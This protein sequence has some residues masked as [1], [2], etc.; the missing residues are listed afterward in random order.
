MEGIGLSHGLF[1]DGGTARAEEGYPPI[2]PGP[3]GEVLR[4][5]IWG[6]IWVQD[7]WCP[8]IPLSLMESEKMNCVGNRPSLACPVG[9]LGLLLW[10]LLS[11]LLSAMISDLMPAS[12][13][14]IT[15]ITQDG[16]KL[17]FSVETGKFSYLQVPGYAADLSAK[18]D[19]GVYLYDPAGTVLLDASVAPVESYQWTGNSLYLLR[20]NLAQ[21]IKTEE[22]WTVYEKHIELGAK[23]T[24]IGSTPMSRAIEAC[25][26]LPL[27]LVGE[28]WHHHLHQS[29]TIRIRSEPY[30]TLL[31][32]LVDIGSSGDGS[33]HMKSDLDFN[34]HGLNLIGDDSFGLAMAIHPEKPAAYYV[35][36]DAIRRS[37]DACFHLGIYK[38]HLENTNSVSF[39]LAFF[40]P[41]DPEWGLRS[42]LQK[43]VSIYPESFVGSLGPQSGMVVGSEYNYNEYPDPKDFHIGAIWNGFKAKNTDYGVHSL[44]YLWPTGF[45]DRGMRLTASS[46]PTGPDPSWEADIAACLSLYQDYDQGQN[47]FQQTCTGP[48]PFEQCTYVNPHGRVY[49]PVYEPESMD[50]ENV[51]AL[52]VTVTNFPNYLFGQFSIHEPLLNSLLQNESGGHVGAM[53]F[54]SAMA[55]LGWDPPY[56]R[57]F[58]GGLN[59]DPGLEISPSNESS[60]GPAPTQTNNFGHL[61]LE[62]AKRANGLYGDAY[63]YTD[64]VEGLNLHNGAAVDTVGAYLRQ[65]FNPDM[66]RV[67][68]LPLGYDS[69]SGR[70]VTLE[71]LA[72]FSFLKALRA[73]LPADAAL[74]MNGKP[75]SGILG[76]ETD[77]LMDEMLGREIDGNWIDELYDEDLQ[78]R[79]RRI[80]RMRMSA[81]Q[82]PITF[83]AIFD[84]AGTEPELLEQMRQYL[85]LYTAKGLYID[86]YRYGYQGEKFFWYEKPHNQS[87]IQE[88]KKHSDAVHALTVAGWEPVPFAEPFDQGGSVIPD[89][90]IERFGKGFFTLYNG[91]DQTVS[92]SVRMDWQNIGLL[93]VSVRDWETGQVLPFTVSGDALTVF[94]LS[95]ERHTVQILEVQPLT[96]YL[97]LVLR[98]R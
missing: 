49:G 94:G 46:V 59:P 93:P 2:P 17:V 12:G 47:P 72:L 50:Y 34:L 63:L 55:E 71:H 24:H 91:G 53:S 8:S 21:E 92:F 79:L 23:M 13:D 45:I 83:W 32:R 25:L 22:R 37:Y 56:S 89:I 29:E 60:P 16:F 62:I 51:R 6:N 87:V 40:S 69:A 20:E 19:L 38:D 97:P 81:Y 82:R 41:D 5:E 39:N 3:T 58:L 86:L 27:D 30:Q 74:S 26:Q 28:R 90:L 66:L 18:P 31:T 54:A 9:F 88:Y 61:N 35:R 43:Y 77:F 73:S 67:A 70:V 78:T 11:M 98:E 1:P 80:N 15:L 33:H 64:P 68:V 57:C 14:T 65:D 52:Q 42:A 36:Y 48:I 95:L 96:V 4:R 75:I 44:V 84:R 85:P 7:V 76:Q 10:M